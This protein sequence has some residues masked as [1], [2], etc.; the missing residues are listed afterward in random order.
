MLVYGNGQSYGTFP[1][2]SPIPV[3]ASGSTT[4][5]IRGV[6]EING[7][8]ALRSDYEVMQGCDTVITLTPGKV[9]LVKPVFEYFSGT[10][11]RWLE[12]FDNDSG[13]ALGGSL[14]PKDSA[15]HISAA[16][17]GYGGG[18]SKCLLLEPNSAQT[19]TLVQKVYAVSLPAQGVGTYLEFNYMGNTGIH[20][21][22][23]GEAS[24]TNLDLG[25]VYPSAGWNKVYLDM[26]EQVSNLHDASGYYYIYIYSI[27][28]PSVGPNQAFIDNI[29]IVTK[30]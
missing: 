29:K 27:Y 28:D 22:I 24:G 15:S 18:N 3:L 23:T 30:Q 6:V 7:V 14:I 19:T 1:I 21:S 4:L 8:S 25:G 5:L 12:N 13:S 20:F 9:T 11:F 2:G 26:T 16:G 10:A 17:Q